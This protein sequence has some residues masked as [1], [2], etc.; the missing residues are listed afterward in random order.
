MALAIFQ[1]GEA[2]TGVFAAL[3][4]HP[5]AD[6]APAGDGGQ[7]QHGAPGGGGGE[8]PLGAL[9]ELEQAH[10]PAVVGGQKGGAA[11]GVEEELPEPLEPL[12]QGGMIGFM[13]PQEGGPV[14]PV[15][16][17]GPVGGQNGK[18]GE[19]ALPFHGIV[20]KTL[21]EAPGPDDGLLPALIQH[22]AAAQAGGGVEH[23]ADIGVVL[24]VQLDGGAGRL[25][26]AL[27]I[28]RPPP[29]LPGSRG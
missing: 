24:G 17:Q 1:E 19:E 12:V 10:D 29:V 18:P 8:L 6:P 2:D 9:D 3:Q 20:E 23:G 22:A 7:G 21:E 27:E 4:G 25:G 28:V 14:L 11:I 26:E 13:E 16:L 15:V 5:E